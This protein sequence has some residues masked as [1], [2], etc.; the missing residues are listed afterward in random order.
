MG[1]LTE[2]Q[3]LLGLEMVDDRNLTSRT[4]HEKVAEG[5]YCCL[6][7]YANLIQCWLDAMRKMIPAD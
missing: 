6:D 3:T 2:E 4:Y 5:I 1:I 7:K